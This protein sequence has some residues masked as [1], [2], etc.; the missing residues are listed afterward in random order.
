[1]TTTDWIQRTDSGGPQAIH[2]NRAIRSVAIGE[3]S[4]ATGLN[5][6]AQG[7]N[8]QATADQAHAEGDG[9]IASGSDSHAEGVATTALG[10]HAHAEGRAT[11]AEGDGSHAEGR[12]TIASG[13]YSHAEGQESQATNGNAHAEGN[14]TRATG[15]NAHAEG[16]G[17]IASGDHSHAEGS[18]T[19]RAQYTHAEGHLNIAGGAGGGGDGL[20]AHAEGRNCTATGAYSHAQGL[21]AVAAYQTQFAHAS[22]RIAVDGDAQTSQ[23]VFLLG[24]GDAP[25]NSVLVFGEGPSAGL[26]LVDNKAYAFRVHAVAGGGVGGAISAYIIK[27]FIVRV[28]GGAA[29]I[30]AQG[31]QIIIGHAT[32]V[33]NW[34]ITADIPGDADL[35]IRFST[36]ADA[37]TT[38]IAVTARVEFVETPIT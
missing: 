31:V 34:L 4:V 33:A 11:T 37:T 19:A 24:P 7:F 25:I 29:T 2:I 28:T 8:A 36:G 32:A 9:N 26:T 1:M 10:D 17:A 12:D 27:D 5:S 13:L 6:F 3:N 20:G 15:A 14:N 30:I 35:N 38:A 22:G 16:N 23:L 18:S 21:R